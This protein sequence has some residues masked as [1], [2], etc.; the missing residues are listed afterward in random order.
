MS[1][2]LENLKF[3]ISVPRKTPSRIVLTD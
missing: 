3:S 2:C 1:G